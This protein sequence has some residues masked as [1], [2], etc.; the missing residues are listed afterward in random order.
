ML[1]REKE[2]SGFK[3]SKP[4]GKFSQSINIGI[5]KLQQLFN[6]LMLQRTCLL[7]SLNESEIGVGLLKCKT[8]M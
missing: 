3:K 5:I 6:A 1:K 7:G 2:A 8:G 4:S